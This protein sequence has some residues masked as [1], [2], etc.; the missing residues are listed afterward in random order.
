MKEAPLS[1]GLTSFNVDTAL[2]QLYDYM[3]KSTT[4]HT[5]PDYEFVHDM[6]SKVADG[7]TLTT[8][9]LLRVQQSYQQ[10]FG[11]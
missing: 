3:T 11:Q 10:R 5:A 1:K 4:N 8:E 7:E 9:E 6:V 2:N